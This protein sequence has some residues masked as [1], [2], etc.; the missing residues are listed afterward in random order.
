MYYEQGRQPWPNIRG[1]LCV[2]AAVAMALSGCSA[3][4]G[5]GPSSRAIVN[6]SK[7]TLASAQ[8]QVLDL[9]GEVARAVVTDEQSLKFAEVFEGSNTLGS[10][11]GKGDVVEVALW[12]APPAVLF[13]AAMGSQLRAGSTSTSQQV[14]L[15]GQMVD[16]NGLITVPFAGSIRAAGRTPAQI[17]REIVARLR[18]KAHQPQAVVR[19]ASNQ[20][21][22]VTVVGDVANSGRL[23]LTPKGERL[24][25]ILAGAG[26]VKN[27]VGKTMIRIT[28]GD[29]VASMPL[30]TVIGDPRQNIV[31]QPDDVI[32]AIYQPYS[33]TALGATSNNAEF[34]ID[35]TGTNL[36]QALGRVG[37]LRE[38]RADIRGIFIFR[39]E[40][41]AKL[42]RFVPADARLTPDG[43]LPVIYRLDLKDPA[44]F[45]VAQSFPIE[46]RD[47]LYVSKAPMADLPKFMNM[48]SSAAF[49]VIGVTNA[50]DNDNQ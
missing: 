11:V 25:D 12:E 10:V 46:N 5:S 9:T 6:A 14:S 49:S 8:I 44:G 17:E 2:L 34:P 50:F 24:L 48:V 32:T 43:K 13:G 26:G 39:L 22:N 41:P 3:F 45:F 21:T 16:E 47:V 23:P 20:A 18:G 37:G 1:E 30:D 19:V 15:P 33:F 27:S 35:A 7:D 38:D 36:A 40:N 29:R 28:R 42:G 4:G 31:I